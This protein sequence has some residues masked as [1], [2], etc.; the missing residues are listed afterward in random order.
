MRSDNQMK[1]RT[2]LSGM[3]LCLVFVSGSLF[4]QNVLIYDHNTNDGVAQTAC[5]NLGFTCTVEGETTFTSALTGGTW[6]LVVL[7]LPSTIPDGAWQTALTDYINGG[8]RA[9]QTGWQTS[10]MNLIAPAF[11]VTLAGAHEAIAFHSWISNPLFLTPNTVPTTMAVAG[12]DWGTNGFYL[13]VVP[14]GSGVAA[15]GFTATAQADQAAS[16]IGNGGRTI[17][18]GFLFDDFYPGDADS[19]GKADIVEYVENQMVF[20]MEGAGISSIPQ[21][22][23][24][25]PLTGPVGLFLMALMLV[26]IGSL[27][28]RRQT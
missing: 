6:D 26:G 21:V 5:T 28:L 4:A 10:S 24:P 18:N 27:R 23:V 9:I 11:E 14:T 15:A 3:M 19:S 17:F 7:D 16:V 13:T 20:L 2:G 8:G 22:A 1:L 12:D 25:V